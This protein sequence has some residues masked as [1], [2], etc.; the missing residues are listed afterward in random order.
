MRC[1]LC[2]YYD[3]TQFAVEDYKGHCQIK[4]PAPAKNE[5]DYGIFPIVSAD[6]WCGQ[7]RRIKEEK[8][9]V[10]RIDFE[11]MLEAAKQTTE[12]Q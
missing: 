11:E 9:N 7:W 10:S 12:K 6:N 4:P 8:D 5:T 3:N 2:E 1:D